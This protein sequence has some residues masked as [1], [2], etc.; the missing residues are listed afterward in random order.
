MDNGT[1]GL[2]AL[3]DVYV[4]AGGLKTI[5]KFQL[6]KTSLNVSVLTSVHMFIFLPFLRLFFT[7]LQHTQ[8]LIFFWSTF[9]PIFRLALVEIKKMHSGHALA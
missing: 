3:A 7:L 9:S 4:H 1:K 2:L 5:Q 8:F 6:L